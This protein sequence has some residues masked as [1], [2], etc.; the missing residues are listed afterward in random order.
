MYDMSESKEI[1]SD[2]A[3][4]DNDNRIRDDHDNDE[5]WLTTTILPK[6]DS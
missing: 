3:T 4:D 5:E 6:S 2:A 1:E